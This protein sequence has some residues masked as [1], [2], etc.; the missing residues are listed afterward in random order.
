MNRNPSSRLAASATTIGALT[1]LVTVV[2]VFLAYNANSGLPFVPTYRV[3][4]EVANAENLV[5]GNEVRI[6]GVRSG[7][8]ERVE[9]VPGENGKATA[10]LHLSLNR[11]VAPLPLDTTYVIRNQSALGLKY[12]EINPGTSA[13]GFEEGEQI[14][15]AAARPEPVEIDDFFNIF[16]EPTRRGSQANLTEF[17]NAFAGR[18]PQINGAIGELRTLVDVAAPALANLADPETRF[19]GFWR[20]MSAAAA[21]VAPVAEQQAELFVGLD[22]TFGAFA[23]VARPYLE[24]TIQKSPETL[25]SVT[26]NLPVFRPFLR[27]SAE[28][29][30]ALQPG[31]AAL[32]EAAPDLAS[33]IDNGVVATREAPRFN[34]QI[35]PTADALLEFQSTPGVF[36]G[37]DLLTGTN[38]RLEPIFSFITPSQTVCNYLTLLF[39][40]A[41][42]ISENGDGIGTWTR[43]IPLTPPTGPNAESGPASAPAN[44][45]ASIVTPP[46]LP[47]KP[48]N[49]LHYNPYPNTAAPGQIRECEAGKEPWAAATTIGNAAG[50]QG[51]LTEGQPKT[52]KKPK[53]KKGK[54]KS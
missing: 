27:H 50:N 2:T 51:T 4:A 21:E 53:K 42:S 7:V 5:D 32:N 23:R 54:G 39:R 11:D 22:E 40:N 34:A 18:G 38:E 45:P 1:V 37:L 13:E 8:V 28:M 3:T 49:Y 47:P 26:P 25:D 30:A 24:E 46:P 12:L 52:K 14:P 19:G 33:A 41:G 36:N 15:I 43:F 20:A 10:R 17:G 48:F 9:P 35:V 44:G 31:A 6:G 16:D 29:F